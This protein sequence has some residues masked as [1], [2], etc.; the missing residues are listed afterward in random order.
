MYKKLKAL[1]AFITSFALLL[2][3][4]PNFSLAQTVTPTTQPLVVQGDMVYLGKFTVPSNDG[5]GRG[6]SVD[7]LDY[8]GFGL[9]MGADGQSIYFGC[10]DWHSMLSRVSIP[11]LGGV[12]TIQM[13]CT[14][15]TNLQNINPGDPNSKKLGGSAVWN[16][17][18]I[19]SAYAFY[20]GNSTALASHFSMST[21]MTSQN[22]P[23]RIGPLSGYSATPTDKVGMQAGY[24]G[25]IPQEWRSLLGG[26]MLTGLNGVAI[27]GRTSFGPTATVF[28]PD[29]LGTSNKNIQMLVGY[30]G[31]HQ[32]LGGY[33]QA[34]PLFSGADQAGGIAFPAGT[35]SL[36]FV[37]RHA[38]TFCYGPGTNDPS[39]AGTSDGQGNLF[40]YDP[41][42]T[43]KGT[44]G[45]PYIH[46]VWAYD[47]N[48][49]LEV[50][51]GNKQPWDIKPYATWRLTEMNNDGSAGP[52]VSATFDPVTK[53]FYMATSRTVHVY[54]VNVG[55]NVVPPPPVPDT[56]A[57][58]V[59]MTAPSSGGTVSGNSV[60]VSAN[61]TD[62]VGVVG[63]QFKVD[64]TNVGSE[65]FSS[66]YSINLDTTS[67]SNGNHVLTSVARDA[68]G[69][70][71]TASSVTVNVANTTPPP[72]QTS[73]VGHWMFDSTSGTNAIDSSGNSNNGTLLNGPVW[74]T[75]K[76]GN[77]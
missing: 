75:G 31:E 8:G 36:L 15:V 60:V 34:N 49:L 24:M 30:P 67:F 16:G 2:T 44:H 69:N 77:A 11:A 28:N 25:V 22:G 45:Y 64:G 72:P 23:Y 32:T 62:N 61:A 47:A 38:T 74:T 35:R 51:K 39:L 46:Q 19:V 10:H 57:P 65:D 27:I 50:K 70:T 52:I 4:F 76:V 13:P 53:R 17:K 42:Q 20:D 3:L 18:L 43:S 59:S 7:S 40:C 26:P 5:T 73:P 14:A 63:V 37:G 68:A 6:N 29:E 48:D 54:Q 33:N 9:G 71:A 12:G 55:N 66:P 56:V 21:N 41:T 1:S 58:V